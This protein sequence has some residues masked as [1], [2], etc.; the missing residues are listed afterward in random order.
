MTDKIAV[1]LPGTVEKIIP[2]I[3]PALPE[4]AQIRVDGAEHLYQEIRIE[5]KLQDEAGNTV[6]LKKG[7]EVEV[8]IAA[9]PEADSFPACADQISVGIINVLNGVSPTVR[10][11]SARA[12]HNASDMARAFLRF[13]LEKLCRD[14]VG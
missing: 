14:T 9:T 10:L 13:D 5:N 11:E 1:T 2:P 12:L 4:K 6:T 8:T 3:A 7:A